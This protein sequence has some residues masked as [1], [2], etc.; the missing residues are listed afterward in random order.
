MGIK[1]KRSSFSLFFRK[2][3]ILINIE[4]I[5]KIGIQFQD[6]YSIFYINFNILLGIQFGKIKSIF[7]I[8]ISIKTWNIVP[9]MLNFFFTY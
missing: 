9:K 1:S 7:Y 6:G 2:V 5:K 4:L 8:L 3:F